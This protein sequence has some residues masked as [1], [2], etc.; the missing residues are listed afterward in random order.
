[1]YTPLILKQPIISSILKRAV[2]AT[3][4]PSSALRLV[5]TC[6]LIFGCTSDPFV[7]QAE[8]HN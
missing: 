6:G 5:E 1:M 3:S 7:C 4:V 8:N 2:L